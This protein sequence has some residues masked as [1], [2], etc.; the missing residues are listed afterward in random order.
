MKKVIPVMSQDG[1]LWEDMFDRPQEEPGN[2][3]LIRIGP[4]AR[5]VHLRCISSPGLQSLPNLLAPL[6]TSHFSPHFS[7]QIQSGELCAP[8]TICHQDAEVTSP[9]ENWFPSGTD[10]P[11]GTLFFLSGRCFVL[12]AP[13]EHTSRK[14]M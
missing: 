7:T 2:Q 11:R 12:V 4:G 8:P 14:R 10:F 6:P 13:G 5:R 1:C 3:A 9:P